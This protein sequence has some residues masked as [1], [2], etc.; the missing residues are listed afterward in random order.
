MK[1]ESGWRSYDEPDT[2]SYGAVHSNLRQYTQTGIPEQTNTIR[3][4]FRKYQSA[5][6]VIHKHVTYIPRYEKKDPIEDVEDSNTFDAEK[7]FEDNANRQKSWF[8]PTN[9]Q[10]KSQFYNP[11]TKKR[12]PLYVA[13]YPR[14]YISK[15]QKKSRS[16]YKKEPKNKKKV[17]MADI[18]ITLDDDSE[19]SSRT[20]LM[21]DSLSDSNFSFGNYEHEPEKVIPS[22]IINDTK[23]TQESNESILVPCSIEIT[24]STPVNKK[25]SI[26]NSIE[27]DPPS[28][29][30]VSSLPDK[31]N[32]Q[33]DDSLKDGSSTQIF[34]PESFTPSDHSGEY[35]DSI[36]V[37]RNKEKYPVCQNISQD[38]I[39]PIEEYDDV[40]QNQ[41]IDDISHSQIDRLFDPPKDILRSSNVNEDTLSLEN[42]DDEESDLFGSFGW[43]D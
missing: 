1:G 27:E 34:T 12:K 31:Q 13:D 9:S 21:D 16:I 28:L 26:K 39:D 15:S 42:E 25:F 18:D 20:Y 17:T 30:I 37:F 2:G 41:E 3:S 43:L 40:S 35:E 14:K 29:R 5:R 24:T 22:S 23:S 6:S 8:R 4:K 33:E 36:I 19:F 38:Y 7:L 10:L 32:I 11:V